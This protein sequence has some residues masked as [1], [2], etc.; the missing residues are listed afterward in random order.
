MHTTIIIASYNKPQYLQ[1]V[2]DGYRKQSN[3]NF[4]VIIAD[5]GST[6]ETK[7]LI[8]KEKATYPVVLKHIW[9]SDKG[10]RKCRILNK[11]ISA[12]KDSEYLIFTDDD[13]IPLPNFIENHLK[14][15]SPNYFLSSGAMRL[16]QNLTDYIFRNGYNA[17]KF[18]FAWLHLHGLPKR[19]KYKRFYW[20]SF[21]RILLDYFLPVK[22]TFN[23]N[24][25]S[26]F[27]AD[28]I[29]VGGFDERMEYYGEDVELGYRLIHSGLKVRR[30]RHRARAIH[31]EHTRGYIT[32]VMISNNKSI[33][34]NT[35]KNKRSFTK[36]HIDF[37][38]EF[39]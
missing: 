33:I 19:L 24:N 28:I 7:T 15:A 3:L 31:L 30:V 12:A 39:K 10:F 1:L 34:V 25:T 9:H 37:N 20:S 29:K 18:N 2:L 36:H 13:C 35:L 11:A 21:A 14:Y 16:P 8:D 32:D 5:D 22:K 26:A 17:I 38:S 4:D 27:R 6:E 23:G